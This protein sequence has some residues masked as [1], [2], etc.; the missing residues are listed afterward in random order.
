MF[1]NSCGNVP[2]LPHPTHPPS[3]HSQHHVRG[4]TQTILEY[5]V[6]LF[7]MF[8]LFFFLW[9]TALIA[10]SPTHTHTPNYNLFYRTYLSRCFA[11]PVR[12]QPPRA[13]TPIHKELLPAE[14]TNEPC[15]MKL[16]RSVL[17]DR[18]GYRLEQPNPPRASRSE[19]TSSRAYYNPCW[20]NLC[21]TGW[22]GAE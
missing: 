15:W 4:K 8:F 10:A 2:S 19:A 13:N 9:Q 11:R 16:A 7:V 17:T 21:L 1:G 12:R 22:R 3:G 5:S 14:R 6:K 18:H 20:C